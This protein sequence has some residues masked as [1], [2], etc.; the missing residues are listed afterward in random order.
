MSAARGGSARGAPSLHLWCIEAVCHEPNDLRHQV[1]AA[2]PHVW[3]TSARGK[4]RLGGDA[5]DRCRC[6]GRR[7]LGLRG[8]VTPRHI[9]RVANDGHLFADSQAPRVALGD[10]RSQRRVSR[11][12]AGSGKV[13]RWALSLPLG[14]VGPNRIGHAGRSRGSLDV[15]SRLGADPALPAAGRRRPLARPTLGQPSVKRQANVCLAVRSCCRVIESNRRVGR[16]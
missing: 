9:H 5:V 14:F 15:S 6:G 10:H 16:W 11:W 8:G 2:D 1:P 12:P 4:A 13:A 7:R 3:A